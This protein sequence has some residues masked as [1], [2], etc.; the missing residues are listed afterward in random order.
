[1]RWPAILAIS[2]A[3]AGTAEARRVPP[4]APAPVSEDFWR[5][6]LDPN[7]V[8]VTKLVEIARLAMKT[9]DD[10]LQS[11]AEWAVEQRMRYWTDTYRLMRYARQL[12]PRNADVLAILGRAAD[13]LGK[14]R[15]ALEALH[16]CIRERTPEKAGAEVLGRLG[17]IYLRLGKTDEAIR[18]LGLVSTGL[19]TD[20][21]QALVHLANALAAR[22]QVS[23]GIDTLINALPPMTPAYYSTELLLGSFALATLYDRDEQRAAAFEV[24]DKMRSTLQTQFGPLVQNALVLMRF[25][26]AEDRHYYQALLYEVTE[27]YVEARAEWALYAAAGDMPWRGRALDH[28]HAIDRKLRA[29]S[30]TSATVP[31]QTKRL[32]PPPPPR[33]RRP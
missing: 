27:Q 12:S 22:G 20:S 15:E 29:A 13:E 2:L 31:A 10:A 24:L 3:A 26:P 33:Q 19:R 32:R 1:M 14:T 28:I 11:D 8:E 21:V 5:D 4:A 6:V 9:H 25:A 23:A 16:A 30:A 17:A 18:W 7:G